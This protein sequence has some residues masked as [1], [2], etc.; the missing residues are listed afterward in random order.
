[1]G[2]SRA[3]VRSFPPVKSERGNR[4]LLA[5]AIEKLIDLLDAIDAK[6]DDREDGGDAE[7]SLAAIEYHPSIYG[8]MAAVISAIS[9]V[10]RKAV[11]TIGMTSTTEASPMLTMNP[12]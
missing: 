3:L 6:T 11:L 4:R 1:M 8:E 12:R 7:P 5:D 9:S 10:G 2:A